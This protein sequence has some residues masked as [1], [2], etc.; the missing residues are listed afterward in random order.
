[1]QMYSLLLFL[2]VLFGTA[3][4]ISSLT[5]LRL[6]TWNLLAP[7]YARETKYPWC[8]PQHLAWEYRQDQIVSQILKLGAD[9]V[10]LQ[11]VQVEA[12]PN[13]LEALAEANYEGHL[14]DVTAGHSVAS[15]ILVRKGLPLSVLRLESRS[16]IFLA[17]L[18]SETS[19]GLSKPIYLCSVHLE[20][21]EED[22][23]T[24]QRFHQ[25]KSIFKRL[26]HHSRI[27]LIHLS[28]ANVVLA[29]D[30]NMLSSDPMYSDITAGCL[31]DP[32]ARKTKPP[33]TTLPLI[34]A[35]AQIQDP[36]SSENTLGMTFAKGYVLDYIWL[37][38]GIAI[39]GAL[40]IHSSAWLHEP[41]KWPSEDHPSDHLP[42]GVQISL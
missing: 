30:F 14:Q 31:H 4:R 7:Q 9:V 26:T 21:G 10:C 20:A 35:F 42:I 8:D 32:E 2:S 37:T 38:P 40:P 29:G 13:L 39:G 6:A 5:T 27:D 23:N 41:Q 33:F 18:D 36:L 24:Q 1:M 11:E 25:L 28:E 34:D 3:Q 12:W 22:N 16:R 17:V 19:T 15:A